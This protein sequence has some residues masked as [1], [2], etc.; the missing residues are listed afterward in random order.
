MGAVER[1]L[2]LGI[3]VVIVAILGIAVWGAAGDD[4]G[5]V[6]A[7]TDGGAVVTGLDAPAAPATV[8]EGDAEGS[9]ATSVD[10]W[11]EL[12]EKERAARGPIDATA[13]IASNT[14]APATPAQPALGVDGAMPAPG[15]GAPTVLK[16]NVPP[17]ETNVT[18]QPLASPSAAPETAPAKAKLSKD[19]AKET[20]SPGTYTVASGDS[21]W[22]IAHRAYGDAD[23]QAHIDAILAANPKADPDN[24]KIGQKLTLPGKV[25]TD[26]NRLPAKQQ[27]A[28]GDGTLYEVATGDTLS[29]IARKKLGD[30]SRWKEIYELNR[31]RISDPANIF[32]G[33]TLRLPKN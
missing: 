13:P 8:A 17:L 9:P 19:S 2:V 30:G 33:T 20:A 28:H 32:V 10:A 16:N 27:V 23:I 11:R 26:I 18:V 22:K 25:A 15:A 31:E 1:V 12:R 21:L 6:V 29:S 14:P 5:K 7:A 3:V 24:L 4:S